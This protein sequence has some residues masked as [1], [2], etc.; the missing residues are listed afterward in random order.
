MEVKWD[1]GTPSCTLTVDEVM[2]DI[3]DDIDGPHPEMSARQERDWNKLKFVYEDLRSG[4]PLSSWDHNTGR[5]DITAWGEQCHRAAFGI[6]EDTRLTVRD[7][8]KRH[9]KWQLAWSGDKT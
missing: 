5:G 3:L 6:Q 4:R 2:P 1:D 8:R 7:L 9:N